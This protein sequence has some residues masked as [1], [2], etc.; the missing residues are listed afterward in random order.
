E[1]GGMKRLTGYAPIFE[2]HDSNKDVIA[3]SAIDFE[4]SILHS[5]TW[6]MI[7]GSFLTAIIPILLAGVA[8]IYLIKRTIAPLQSITQFAN[9]VAEGDLT[10]ERLTIKGNDEIGQLSHDLNKMADNLTE[11]IGDL[12]T[13]S[14][15][16][17]TTSS[18]LTASVEQVSV[19]AEENL[20]SVNE[21][22]VGS[23]E[24]VN[25]VHSTNQTLATISDKTDHI[26]ERS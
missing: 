23:Q 2:D 8:T 5:R 17:A 10:T 24:Q 9:R 6:D 7:K 25:I 14:T 1:F 26:S 22:K 11:I 18:E 4:S 16:V 12:A 19:V 20:Q 3:I 21:V 13:S 15:Q